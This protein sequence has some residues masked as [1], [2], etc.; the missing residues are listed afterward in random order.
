MRKIIESGETLRLYVDYTDVD[1]GEFIDPVSLVCTVRSPDGVDTPI[2]YPEPDFVKV[3]VGQYFIRILGNQVGTWR[4]R[5]TAPINA[6][7][8][9]VRDGKF[10]VE[11]SL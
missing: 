6:N 5:I 1:T 9:D 4:Y 7:D 10:D 11:P 2:V 3:A 8:I